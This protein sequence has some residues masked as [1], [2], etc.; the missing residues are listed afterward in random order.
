[1]SCILHSLLLRSCQY[2]QSA[3]SLVLGSTAS[4]LNPIRFVQAHVSCPS[5]FGL[6]TDS[7]AS[8]SFVQRFKPFLFYIDVYGPSQKTPGLSFQLFNLAI[9][10]CLT[11]HA[12]CLRS[13]RDKHRNDYFWWKHGLHALRLFLRW[14]IISSLWSL[15]LTCRQY[16]TPFK[17]ASHL[18]GAI[19]AF[20][21]L[22]LRSAFLEDGYVLYHA[23]CVSSC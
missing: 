15:S 16:S 6:T 12:Q 7:F 10:L 20:C 21:H 13:S 22:T 23:L 1:M 8:A 11:L 5:S 2:S 9:P 4:V 18:Y 19:L 14:P 17:R 3:S